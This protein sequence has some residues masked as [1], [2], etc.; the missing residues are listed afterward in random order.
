MDVTDQLRLVGLVITDNLSWRANTDS[1]IRRAF[2]KLWILRRL[3]SLGAD[4]NVLKLVY[5]RHV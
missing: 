1:M 5:F 3:K 4:F 2:A